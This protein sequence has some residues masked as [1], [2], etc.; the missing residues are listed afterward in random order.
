MVKVLKIHIEKRK[1]T[2]LKIMNR[3]IY[4][5]N[6]DDFKCLTSVSFLFAFFFFCFS[7]QGFHFILKE[8]QGKSKG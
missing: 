1:M 6:L 7:G 4:S 3:S 8:K 2:I 5:K